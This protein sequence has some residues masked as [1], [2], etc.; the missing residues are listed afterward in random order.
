MNLKNLKYVFF[1]LMTVCMLSSC[2]ETNDDEAQLE[3]ANWQ[4]RNDKAF[5]DTLAYAKA[6]IAAGSTDWKIFLNWSL[7]NQT[8]N[9]DQSGNSINLTYKDDDYIV[10]HVLHAGEGEY[11]PI[12]TDSIQMSY[13]GRIIP[14][15]SNV[16]GAVFDQT[17]T[18]DFSFEKVLPQKTVINYG[19]IDGF[20][21]AL[22]NMRPGDHWQVFIP[23]NLGYGS[24]A[25]SSI[26]AY[27]M[28]RFE[29]SLHAY[30]RGKGSWKSK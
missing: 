17:F 24:E 15:T 6:Q 26:P 12:Y 11:L 4:E 20:T 30:K 23:E 2:S 8:P 7:E 28:L 16:N 3:Y 13:R 19:Y 25:N 10:V 22:L 14:T 27:S 9:K 29:M 21:T 1:L 5:A 18:G